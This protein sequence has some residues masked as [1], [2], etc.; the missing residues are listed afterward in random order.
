MSTARW[1]S[2]LLVVWS[3]C[4]GMMDSEGGGEI[5]NKTAM[6][7]RRVDPEDVSV[8]PG[9]RIEVVATGLT[10]PTGVAFGKRGEIYLVESGYSYGETFTRPRLVEIDRDG[11]GVLSEI[12][13]GEHAPWNGL[14]VADGSFFVAE[15]G[16]KDGGR[17]VRIERDGTFKV[18]VSDLPSTGDHHTDGPVVGSDGYVYFGQGT[19]TNSGVVGEDSHDFGWLARRPTMHDVPCR[20][21]TLAGKNFTSENPLTPEKGD[22]ATTGAFSPFGTAT[23]PGQVVAGR[24]PCNGAVMRVPVAGGPVELVAWGFRNPFGL[25]FASDGQLYVTDNGYDVR[26]SRPVFGS[27]D[28]LW[29][30]ERGAWY[31]WPDFAD[32]RPLTMDF[33]KEAGGDPHGFVLA[34]HPATPPSPIALFPVHSSADG[35][36]FSRSR[37]FGYQGDAFVALFGDMTPGTGKVMAPVGYTVVRVNTKSGA[38]EDFARNRGDEKG[39]A[40]RRGDGGLE[41]PVAV[42]FD[43]TGRALYVVDFGVMRTSSK[44]PE[45][46]PE[47]G[48]LWRIVRTKGGRP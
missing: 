15:G 47:T 31:G 45:S 17:I 20:D 24:L 39:P 25:A 8:P 23:Q 12:A 43:P 36:D 29:R 34:K 16:E 22:K 10:F 13:T 2:V 38:I 48:V 32:G 19:A 21:V 14:A 35:F 44:G 11:G 33:Y 1:L 46:Q 37:E 40:S 5:S 3:G 18:L 26:G 27:A 9:Y 42:R 30:V 41:R 4:Y 6:K 7:G 28:W